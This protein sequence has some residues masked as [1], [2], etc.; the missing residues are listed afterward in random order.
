M[1]YIGSVLGGLF[2]TLFFIFIIA[3]IGYLIGGIEIKGISLGTAGVLLVALLFGIMASRVGSFTVGETDIT[4][5]SD[6]IKKMFSLVSNIGT[7]L[8][9]SGV[10]LIAGPKFFRSLTKAQRHI[11]SWA[12]S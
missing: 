10:G 3:T 9:V 11:F 6:N 5:W 1:V 7:A 4:L 12:L 8:F 2:T